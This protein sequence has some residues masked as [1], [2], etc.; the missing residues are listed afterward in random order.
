MEERFLELA[1]NKDITDEELFEEVCYVYEKS[2]HDDSKKIFFE[3]FKNIRKSNPYLTN[4]DSLLRLDH[5]I[6]QV[7]RQP[8]DSSTYFI[9]NYEMK[10][11][12]AVS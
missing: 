6:P 7:Y 4:K 12:N 5:Q 1:K 11:T 3:R 10:K 2:K 9:E 8:Y